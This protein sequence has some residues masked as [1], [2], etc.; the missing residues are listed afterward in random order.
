MS[1][2]NNPT[3]PVGM[4]ID[5]DI[6]S[7]TPP[8][9]EVAP[10]EVVDDSTPVVDP[11]PEVIDAV[12][13]VIADS[14]GLPADED[15]SNP[16][17]SE[18]EPMLAVF[19]RQG[20][21]QLAELLQDPSSP[22]DP[23]RQW[24]E[25]ERLYIMPCTPLEF[26]NLVANV[27]R[28]DPTGSVRGQ[29]WTNAIGLGQRHMPRAGIGLD[30]LTREGG[31]WRQ[32]VRA[33][34]EG[35]LE[36]SA[37]RPKLGDRKGDAPLV[38]EEAL[39]F[40]QAMMGTGQITRIPLWHSG[41]WIN[42]KAPT[43]AQLLE[44]DRRI[45]NEKITLG[46]ATAGLAY[47][48]M[49]V[50]HNAFLFNFALSLVFDCSISG[51]T[52]EKLKQKILLP[53]L[54]LL[55]WGLLCTIYPN[56]YR[57]HRPC[58]ADPTICQHVTEELLDISKLCWTDNLALTQSQRN[59]MVRKAT[60][61]TDIELE[62]YISQHRYNDKGTFLVKEVGGN[63]TYVELRV[64]SLA[65]YEQSGYSWVEGIVST[66]DQAFGSQL[67]TDERDEYILDQARATSLRQYAH[68]MKRIT[69]NG[70]TGI[71]D[72]NTLET[73]V[74]QLTGDIEASDAFM[75]GVRKFINESTISQIAIPSYKCPACQTDQQNVEEAKH[76][77][78]IPL[79][80]GAIFFTLLG[81][82]THRLLG[83]AV[84]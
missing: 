44:L 10:Q 1:N 65:D 46:R 51:F 68:W 52:T 60:K 24:D 80:I 27:R 6:V 33:E 23:R 45:A 74:A 50:Y 16:A 59:H 62:N 34:G 35:S 43:E 25:A 31:M 18:D 29:Q 83:S 28:L 56:G 19:L 64:P 2:E 75:E 41:I 37:G 69:F 76:P 32:K 70:T 38:G 40:M 13:P 49:S 77:H 4:E 12:S 14:I 7:L 48:N 9:V 36:I 22:L 73:M 3:S 42:I 26:N 84:I 63:K 78:L 61:F 20:I 67:G 39:Q 79:D 21:N 58:I 82:R 30:A 66:T 17:G 55:L 8:V 53:D 57:Y 15:E 47:S 71:E 11:T 81:Q 54:P 72:R 5:E